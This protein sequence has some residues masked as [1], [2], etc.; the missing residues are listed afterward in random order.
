[1]ADAAC[2]LIHCSAGLP[3]GPTKEILKLQEK[4]GNDYIVEKP[5]LQKT[6]KFDYDYFDKGIDTGLELADKATKGWSTNMVAAVGWAVDGVSS[7]L[8]SVGRG[9]F[10]LGYQVSTHGPSPNLQIPP[11][12]PDDFNGP[13]AGGGA[14]AVM[15]M[16][17]CVPPFCAII[18]VGVPTSGA[19]YKPN[20]VLLSS[21]GPSEPLNSSNSSNSDKDI[22][23]NEGLAIRKDLPKHMVGPD[24]FTPGKLHGT[25]NL[26]NAKTALDAEGANY[27]IKPTNTPGISELEYSVKNPKNGK[28]ITGYKTVYDP[29]VY[30]DEIMLKNSQ[31]AGRAAWQQYLK[32]PTIKKFDSIQGGVSFRSYINFDNGNAYIGNVH[33]IK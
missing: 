20:N 14:V 26:D 23:D 10:N 16:P 13:W 2:A 4:R 9:A 33:P 19:G 25:H 12:F 6:G 30:S 5:L 31:E 3:E 24:G 28:M 7:E 22:A 17:V 29:K 15:P 27:I 1:M 21:G 11:K 32:D 18:P 8:M